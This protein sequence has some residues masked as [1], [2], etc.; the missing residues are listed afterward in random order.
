LKD[1]GLV[2]AYHALRGEPQGQESV[3]TLYPSCGQ[4]SSLSA[5]R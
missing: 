1:L 5:E 2:S 4:C 3:P